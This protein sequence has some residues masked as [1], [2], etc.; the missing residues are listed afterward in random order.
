MSNFS[1]EVVPVAL[2]SHPNADAL[3]IVKVFDNYVVCVRTEDWQGKTIGAYIPPDSIVPNNE[4]FK[5]LDGHLRI[6][7]KKLRGVPSYGML[8]PAP[9]GSQIGDNVAEQLGILHYEPELSPLLKAAQGEAGNPPPVEGPV[10]DMENW[11]KY[12]RQFVDGE[13]V[14]ITEKLHGSNVR[15]TCQNGQMFCGSHYRWPREGNNIYWNM[16]K[17]VP[18]IEAFCHLNQDAVLYGEIFGAIQKGYNY[19]S[20]NDNP[21]QFR[22]F[23]VF[24]DGRFL[25]YDNA[26]G[27]AKS[28]FLVPVLYRGPYSRVKVEE[29]TDGP[30]VIEG[31]SNIREGCVVKPVIERFSKF[32]RVILKSVSINY[33]DEKKK[34]HA[35]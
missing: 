20:T 23:D 24:A 18:W 16:L 8:I 11:R 4:Q 17:H 3:S 30:S 9:E 12:S 27:G 6:K 19:G 10:Y 13:E 2:E 1:V 26:L 21:Y 32:G 25:D 29:F 33:L 5:F 31:A 7:A 35:T 22:A 15:F 14:V 34:R 28:N